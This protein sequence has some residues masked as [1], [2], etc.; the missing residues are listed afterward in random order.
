MSSTTMKL[1]LTNVKQVFLDNRSNIGCSYIMR[2]IL[3][4]VPVWPCI[5]IMP[6]SEYIIEIRSGGEYII[7]RDISIEVYTRNYKTELGNKQL[8]DIISEIVNVCQ[9]QNRSSS[10]RWSGSVF[11]CTWGTESYDTPFSYDGQVVQIGILPMTFT[12]T[13]TIPASRPIVGTA[14]E[15]GQSD[16]IDYINTLMVTYIDGTDATFDLTNVRQI[17]KKRIPPR[18]LYP[19]ITIVGRDTSRD[20]RYAGADVAV[21]GIEIAVWTKLLDK[22]VNL[23]M[24]LD[25]V[26]VVKDVCQYNADWNG[27][28]ENSYIENIVY[29]RLDT[30]SIGMSY[31]SRINIG[32]EGRELIYA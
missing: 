18:S 12:S 5:A 17:N 7:R 27:Q 20:R 23:D 25:I 16:L 8:K 32:I 11:D 22:E 6:E 28:C 3:P 9:V 30:G 1:L 29:D 31:R 10:N 19:G 26:E 15:T 2:G 4:P 24:N 14:T 13:E 21:N